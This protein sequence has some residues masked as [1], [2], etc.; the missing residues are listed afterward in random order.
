MAEEEQASADVSVHEQSNATIHVQDGDDVHTYNRKHQAR[1]KHIDSESR[2]KCSPSPLN[3]DNSR[4]DTGHFNSKSGGLYHNSDMNIMSSLNMDASPN[5]SQSPS[6]PVVSSGGHKGKDA[7]MIMLKKPIQ[8]PDKE[9]YDSKYQP[10][11]NTEDQRNHSKEQSYENSLQYVAQMSDHS[12]RDNDNT[13]TYRVS[14][15]GADVDHRY[16]QINQT[17]Q[18]A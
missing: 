3:H 11:A 1:T 14:N 5:G 2:A 18:V 16:H 8:K 13:E 10:Y 15:D 9:K 6:S 4:V 7:T 12:S 17:D